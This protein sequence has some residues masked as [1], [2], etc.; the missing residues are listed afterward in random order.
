MKKVKEDIDKFIDELIN[1]GD[2]DKAI[3]YLLKENTL[4]GGEGKLKENVSGTY[5][6]DLR[7]FQ[8]N[9]KDLEQEA[10]RWE[11]DKE[12]KKMYKKDLIALRKIYNALKREDYSTAL[13][14]SEDLDTAILD[15]IPHRL[16]NMM[17]DRGAGED[18]Y[19]E[20]R[21]GLK[22][23]EGRFTPGVVKG[24]KGLK[25]MKR[26]VEIDDNL[27]GIVDNAIEEVKTLISTYLEENPE[28]EWKEVSD[29]LNYDGGVD[30]IIDSS[31]P[32][33]TGEIK[34]LWFLHSNEFEEAYENAGIG[35]NPMENNGMVGIYCYISDKVNNW[36]YSEGEDWVSVEKDHYGEE[37]V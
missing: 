31:V 8:T 14:V 23:G 16:L 24:K 19:E 30:E 17:T 13:R 18:V 26:T 6:K 7:R 29:R 28:A 33:Y 11:D 4:K 10:G 36:L 5:I 32:V 25:E 2:I 15:E 20:G 27:D 1:G 22:E 37:D 3:A 12:M 9:I 35:D 21:L 34:G